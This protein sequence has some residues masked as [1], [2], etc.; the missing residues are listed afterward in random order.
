M[1]HRERFKIGSSYSHRD[2]VVER[3]KSAK[4]FIKSFNNLI[5]ETPD[6]IEAYWDLLI[7]YNN[8]DIYASK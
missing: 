3:Y 5:I 6:G 4:S 1:Y 2:V 8:N 7:Y